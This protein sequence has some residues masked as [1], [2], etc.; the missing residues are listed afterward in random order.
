MRIL[1]LL[2]FRSCCLLWTQRTC[3]IDDGNAWYVSGCGCD[4]YMH[5][6]IVRQVLLHFDV[7]TVCTLCILCG[8][9]NSDVRAMVVFWMEYRGARPSA[10]YTPCTASPSL[11]GLCF[12][13]ESF[14]I[15]ELKTILSLLFPTRIIGPYALSVI[16]MWAFVTNTFRSDFGLYSDWGLC[17]DYPRPGEIRVK[18]G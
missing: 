7:C 11:R 14:A 17:R 15:V 12:A 18:L 8:C 13:F 4:R 9:R 5:G 1:S 6:A 3:S 2:Y 10:A 16:V